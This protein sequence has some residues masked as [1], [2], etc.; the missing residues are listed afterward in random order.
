MTNKQRYAVVI[1]PSIEYT[2]LLIDVAIQLISMW[3]LFNKINCLN[4]LLRFMLNVVSS[5]FLIKLRLNMNYKNYYFLWS[6]GFS[7]NNNLWIVLLTLSTSIASIISSIY[8]V[9]I[10]VTTSYHFVERC[11]CSFSLNYPITLTSSQVA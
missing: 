4:V 3:K 2:C 5:L 11:R 7:Y 6:I 10:D 1:S 8:Y 9:C